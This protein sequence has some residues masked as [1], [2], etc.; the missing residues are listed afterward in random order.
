MIADEG[1]LAGE[2]P[3]NKVWCLV[4]PAVEV[5]GEVFWAGRIFQ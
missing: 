5:A 3:P 4:E 1:Y 2:V